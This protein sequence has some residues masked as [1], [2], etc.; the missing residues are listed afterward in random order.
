MQDYKDTLNLPKTDFPMKA[1][2]ANREP[3]MVKYWREINLYEK[4]CQVTNGR[5]V[6]ILHDG[7]PYANGKL[8]MGHAL[9]KTLKDIVVKSKI[10]SGF[11]SPYIPG[12]DCHGLPIEINIEKKFGR[13]GDKISREEFFQECRK[14]ATTQVELQKEG[15]ERLGVIGDWNN[16]YLSMRHSFEANVVRSLAKIINNGHLVHGRKP[17]HWCTQCGSALAEAEV[18]Y[19]DKTSPSIDVKFKVIDRDDFIK[20]FPATNTKKDI[21]VPIW[22]TT[23]WTLPANQAVS[24]NPKFTYVLVETIDA[25]LLIVEDLL[26]DV[27]AR[28]E[29]KDFDQVG[30]CLG[31]ALEGIKLQHP[32][33]ER[34]VPIILGEHVT[35]EAGTGAVHTAPGHGL[36]DYVVG[37]HYG[38][39]ID[40]PVDARGCFL[41]ST[42]FFAGEHVFKANEHVLEVL[43]EKGNLIHLEMIQHSYPHC[44]RHKTPLIFRATPQWF[45]SMDKNGLRE[46]VL[47]E[48][49]KVA[50]LPDWGKA[51]IKGMIETRPDWCISRQRTWFTPM[52]LFVHKETAKLHPK[53]QELVEEVAKRIEQEGVE[54]WSKISAE[55]MLGEDA[56]NYEK[57][58]DTLDVWFDSGVTHACVLKERDNLKVPAELYLEGSDQH[59]GWFQSSLLTAVAMYGHA[60]YKTVLTHGFVVDEK[61]HKMSKSVG[62]VIAPEKICKTYG[63]DILRLWIASADYSAEIPLSDESLKRAADAYRRI[64][65]TAR[66]LLSNLHDF[67]SK[68]H[69]IKKEQMLAL[70]RWA[71]DRVRLLQEEIIKDYAEFNFHLIYQKVHNFCTVDMG[72]FYLDIIKDRQYTMQKESIGRR[73]AQTAIYFILQSLVRLIS[74]IL[75]FTAEEIWRHILDADTESVFL[76]TWYE[77]L[78]ALAEDEQMNQNYWRILMDVRNEVNKEL[79]K[80][81][82][83]GNIGSALGADVT[84]YCDGELAEQLKLLGDELRFVFITASAK[85]LPVGDKTNDAIET[86][87]PNLFIQTV[88]SPYKKCIRCWH[89]RDDVGG[90]KA[91]PEIC[92]RCVTNVAGKGEERRFA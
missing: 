53:T 6:Y 24:L 7:P 16:P 17:V 11:S 63:A 15:F 58:T 4:R 78:F 21:V 38:L 2:L 29:I 34:E 12:W 60:P 35:V 13:P 8:H 49:D 77:N 33:L 47:A 5:D 69:A 31:E 56:K 50:W 20:C 86:V 26:N 68:K 39:P 71:V 66:F 84:L 30:S 22:T 80:Q 14:F 92:S 59:R 25:Y 57:V 37:S 55:E 54:I 42:E 81:R 3:E 79:E 76:T 74:P 23:P 27:L 62:N 67:E 9:N 75:S 48:I 10:L 43:K 19:K 36:D 1:N 64:R 83:A 87:I 91:H 18:E 28:Y 41:P 72:S 90:D 70:D 82:A 46:Q 45:I 88:A 85:V 61:G 32:F 52:T 44:W 65:N 89:Y 73:S 51:R 40:N